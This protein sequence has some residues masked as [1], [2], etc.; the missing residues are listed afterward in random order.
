MLLSLF[1]LQVV[2]KLPSGSCSSEFQQ[3]AYTY[4]GSV[5]IGNIV[6]DSHNIS[7][8]TIFA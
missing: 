7:G 2:G 8:L 4:P 5:L 1:D 3:L 6:S